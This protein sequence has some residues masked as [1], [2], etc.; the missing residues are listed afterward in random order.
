MLAGI[1]LYLTVFVT[2]LAINMHWVT[3]SPGMEKLQILGDPMILTVAGVM[4]VLEFVIDKCPYADNTWD[5]IHTIIRPIGGA[6]L[7]LKA[8]GT[9]DPVMEVVAVLLGGT[10]AFTSHAAKA[11]TRVMVN[12]SPEPFSNIAVSTG[13]DVAVL[14]GLYLAFK[15]PIIA[16]ILVVAFVIGFWYFAPK[17]FRAVR[18]NVTGITHRFFA[19]RHA[20]ELGGEMPKTIPAFAHETWLTLQRPN[21]EPVW[22]IPGFSGKMKPLGRNVRGCLVATTERRLFFIGRKNF[23][24]R[25]MEIPMTGAQVLDDPGAV[26]HRVVLKTLTGGQFRVRFTRKFSPFV[27]RI[28]HWMREEK[29][30]PAGQLAA[31]ETSAATRL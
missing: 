18:A 28:I 22:A 24:A 4:L 12:L 3:L 21:E 17:F 11:G 8:I 26:F 10:V 31:A 27:P 7:A 20:A 5:S 29:R 25:F 6:F 15:H 2:G 9:T 16:L 23:R 14:G 30:E 19:R 13:E 1:N